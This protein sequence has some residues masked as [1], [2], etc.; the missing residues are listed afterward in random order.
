MIT[1]LRALLIAVILITM[2]L[3]VA[4]FAASNP[5]VASVII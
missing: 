3:G 5:M 4:S 2:T 1:K